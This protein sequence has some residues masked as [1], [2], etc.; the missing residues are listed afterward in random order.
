[1]NQLQPYQIQT[2]TISQTSHS[3]LP[4][5]EQ[6][7]LM[8]EQAKYLLAS[9][10]LPNNI[11]RPEQV[12]M[13]MLK[14]RE[15]GI[16]P[17]HA[18]SHINII[19]GKPAMS[20]ELMLSQIYRLH[21]RAQIKFEERTDKICHVKAKRDGGQWQDFKFTI[22][23]AQT[24]QLTRNPSW[25][26][27]PRA[28]L[29]ARVISEMA[30][31]LFPDAISGIS[32]TPEELGENVDED[33]TII[34]DVSEPIPASPPPPAPKS[35]PAKNPKLIDKNDPKWIAFL[36]K[37]LAEKKFPDHVVTRLIE[38]MDGAQWTSEALKKAYDMVQFENEVAK[39]FK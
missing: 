9:G 20:A 34:A 29:H 31:S 17:I 8:Q 15:L 33:G 22:E 1:M 32:Y 27:Y 5:L 39:E 11:Q 23:N 4:G 28:M 7:Q 18:L 30:R 25:A 26:K 38:L 16:P 21:P 2:S 13:I 35:E 10:Y 12:I 24:A 19:N 6:W 14:G 37:Y 36:T 3:D